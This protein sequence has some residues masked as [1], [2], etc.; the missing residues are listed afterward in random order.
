MRWGGRCGGTSFTACYGDSGG[1]ID[2]AIC[3]W[4]G[5]MEG[6]PSP[7][8]TGIQVAPKV[9]DVTDVCIIHVIQ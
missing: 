5:G 9:L 3:D 6:P 4:V 7:H 1:A 8:V 2:V